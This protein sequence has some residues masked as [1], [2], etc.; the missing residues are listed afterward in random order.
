M[1]RGLTKD[2]LSYNSET[3]LELCYVLSLIGLRLLCNGHIDIGMHRVCILYI[4]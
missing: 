1:D 4:G 3:V 2:E